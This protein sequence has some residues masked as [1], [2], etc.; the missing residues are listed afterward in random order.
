MNVLKKITRLAKQYTNCLN[1]VNNKEINFETF[2]TKRKP[3]WNELMF[4]LE[5]Y[6]EQNDTARNS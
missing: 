3:I 2:L 6:K 4:E 1:Q 5:K